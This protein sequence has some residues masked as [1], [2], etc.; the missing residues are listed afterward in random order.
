MVRYA[1]FAS[2]P[3]PRSTCGQASRLT[4]QSRLVGVVA[5]PRKG[6][7]KLKSTAVLDARGHGGFTAGSARASRHSEALNNRAEGRQASNCVRAVLTVKWWRQS[8]D[9]HRKRAVGGD[10]DRSS[11]SEEVGHDMVPP[12]AWCTILGRRYLGSPA[13]AASPYSSTRRPWPGSVSAGGR[14][15]SHRPRRHRWAE[16]CTARLQATA[17]LAPRSICIERADRRR[18]VLAV[19]G[20]LSLPTGDHRVLSDVHPSAPLFLF[21]FAHDPARHCRLATTATGLNM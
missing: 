20:G 18:P 14:S 7:V 8:G 6:I 10:G 19:Q 12:G 1:S 15:S 16:Q 11:G 13:T 3:S 21:A 2:F 4:D 9:R 5:P 17:S